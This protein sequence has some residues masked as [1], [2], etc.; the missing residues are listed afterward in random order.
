M[1]YNQRETRVNDIL[2][3][4]L[5]IRTDLITKHKVLLWEIPN[6]KADEKNLKL[7]LI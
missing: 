3:H 2:P 6:Y 5:C 7:K 4:V 1:L